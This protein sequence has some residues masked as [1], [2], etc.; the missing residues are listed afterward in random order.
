[1]GVEGQRW[2]FKHPHV[3]VGRRGWTDG[4]RANDAVFECS[5]DHISNYRNEHFQTARYNASRLLP[6][7]GA[8]GGHG[9]PYVVCNG[10]VVWRQVPSAVW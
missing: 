10:A 6:D 8:A 4:R 3:R 1:M 7:G 5:T 9:V 2:T